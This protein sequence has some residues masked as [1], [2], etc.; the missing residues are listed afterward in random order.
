MVDGNLVTGRTYHD[1]TQLLKAFVLMLKGYN[2]A[3]PDE[4]PRVEEA[5]VLPTNERKASLPS[6]N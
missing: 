3:E 4:R 5:S 6:A 2:Q 1:N